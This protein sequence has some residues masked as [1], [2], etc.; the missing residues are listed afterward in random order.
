MKNDFHENSIA[1]TNDRLFSGGMVSR[2]FKFISKNV[3][4]EQSK[5]DDLGD[6]TEPLSSHSSPQLSRRQFLKLSGKGAVGYLASSAIKIP[7]S[8][9]RIGISELQQTTEQVRQDEVLIHERKIEDGKVNTLVFANEVCFY[10]KA[11]ATDSNNG[12]L[13]SSN[14]EFFHD[15]KSEYLGFVDKPTFLILHTDGGNNVPSTVQ[16]LNSREI[17]CQFVVGH[18]DDR[19]V[20]IQTVYLQKN[21]VNVSGTTSGGEMN[22]Y[23]ANLQFWG[24]L[25]V[26]INGT[27]NNVENDL[28][29]KTVELCMNILPMYD[30]KISQV[31]G[32]MEVPNNGKPDPG[33]EVLRN[34]RTRIYI[35]L[36]KSGNFN[37]I[38]IFPDDTNRIEE[39]FT[40]ASK[41]THPA[42]FN[43]VGRVKCRMADND[44]FI[45]W[46]AVSTFLQH[47][48][49]VMKKWKDYREG[50]AQLIPHE[51]KTPVKLKEMYLGFPPSF[52]DWLRLPGKP[53]E[54][55]R[56]LSYR[57]NAVAKFVQE[58]CRFLT[59][60][61]SMV[62]VDLPLS[63]EEI[64]NL[65]LL[66]ISNK[67]YETEH[68]GAMTCI[69]DNR[70]NVAE[71]FTMINEKYQTRYGMSL[72][73]PK[74]G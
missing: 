4:R 66:F 57:P 14:N 42:E 53:L 13:P 59:K 10:T 51:I 17:Q 61:P 5:L 12:I 19:P 62:G 32:H 28:R 25:N 60:E 15:R 50:V 20:S 30:L 9:T 71:S 33:G 44:A 21:R 24:S 49:A 73:V 70:G 23:E 58:V 31:I 26:E 29:D 68:G 37:L 11:Q 55:E 38:D 47:E 39:L 2:L 48:S 40:V 46:D 54:D 64:Q 41:S 3:R 34:I 72:P 65:A 6:V 43:L 16:G 22:P 56:F 45:D 69:V 52:V 1:N 35:E 8:V 36:L 27:P 67:P 18:I 7:D 63:Y 74:T